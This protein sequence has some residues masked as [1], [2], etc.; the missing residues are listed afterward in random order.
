MTISPIK[1]IIILSSSFLSGIVIGVIY[2]V[3]KRIKKHLGFSSLLL[4]I[5]DV[6][7]F[8]TLSFCAYCSVYII[9]DGKVRWYEI[10]G[11]FSGFFM[12]MSFFSPYIVRLLEFFEGIIRK[13]V[14][15]IK[16]VAR[17]V[18]R[19]LKKVKKVIVRWISVLKIRFSSQKRKKLLIF[20][21]IKC[22]F[23][24]I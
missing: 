17:P 14:K 24:K 22:I 9:N 11:I 15:L 23:R 18:V 21:K 3:L 12:Y 4:D 7:T 16:S 20:N 8:M 6:I 2:D 1:E 19:L 10:F 5:G 13:L